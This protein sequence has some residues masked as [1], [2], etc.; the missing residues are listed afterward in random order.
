M[1][2]ST[3]RAW[4]VGLAW[5]IIIPGVNQF[6][7]FRYPAVGISPVRG[8]FFF[9]G[10]PVAESS[11]SRKDCLPGVD[12]PYV[13]GLGSLSAERFHLWRPA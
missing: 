8:I 10:G 4:V 6:F 11:P 9:G 5:A 13:Q 2:L 12:F 7:F 3:L 1:P